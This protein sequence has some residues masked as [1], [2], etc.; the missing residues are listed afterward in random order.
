MKGTTYAPAAQEQQ[1][2]AE[3]GG[4]EGRRGG[5]Q[6]GGK[7]Q[8]EQRSVSTRRGATERQAWLEEM[9]RR[10]LPQSGAGKTHESPRRPLLG[11][12]SKPLYES[13]RRSCLASLPLPPPSR[14]RL[15]PSTTHPSDNRS[16][17]PGAVIYS[18]LLCSW[19]IGCR[20]KSQPGCFRM[21]A[22][23]QR[24]C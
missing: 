2:A 5:G 19:T 12:R 8:Q 14:P 23:E 7:A 13:T 10:P 1:R 21:A 24:S 15:L 17:A 3:W 9:N 20:W 4:G 16:R 11:E 6:G 22:G 18:R